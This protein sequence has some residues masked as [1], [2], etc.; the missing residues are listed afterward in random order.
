MEERRFHV[1]L[2]RQDGYAF[3]TRFADDAWPAITIDEPEPLGAGSGPNASR[4][5]GAA[6]GHCLAASLLF[7]LAKSRVTVDDLEVA[8]DGTVARNEAGRL[9]VT[10][11]QVTITP[12]V[13]A[14][15]QNRMQRCLELFEDFCLVTAS[16]RKGIPIHVAV[17]PTARA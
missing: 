15:E 11:I 3:T 1:T 4:M 6:I 17:A 13:P 14:D 7:C 10:E 9:R 2:S 12:T 5:L 16:V 8:V